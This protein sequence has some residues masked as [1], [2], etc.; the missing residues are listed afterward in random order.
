MKAEI[1]LTLRPK[2]KMVRGEPR[3]LGKRLNSRPIARLKMTT[4][5][6]PLCN[7]DNFDA[8][9]VI[10]EHQELNIPREHSCEWI[11]AEAAF[12]GKPQR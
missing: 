12:T 9:P 8:E 6:D 7:T 5:P 2:D 11:G 10:D 1:V 4:V 3:T